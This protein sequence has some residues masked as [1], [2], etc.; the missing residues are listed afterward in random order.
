MDVTPTGMVIAVRSLPANASSPMDVT[1]AGMVAMPAQNMPSVTTVSVMVNV[2]LSEHASVVVVAC[3]S[4]PFNPN[5]IIL[6]RS[7]VN[8]R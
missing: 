7:S 3:A 5:N 6:M 2:P 8:I 1:P 4:V